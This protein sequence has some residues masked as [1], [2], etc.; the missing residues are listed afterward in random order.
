MRHA[1]RLRLFEQR[2]GALR[3]SRCSERLDTSV[4]EAVAGPAPEEPPARRSASRSS[5]EPHRTF[6]EAEQR[7]FSIPPIKR[8]GPNAGHGASLGRRK[9]RARLLT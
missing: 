8:R 4:L 2:G 1:W 9:C 7:R 6:I 5:C 3:S